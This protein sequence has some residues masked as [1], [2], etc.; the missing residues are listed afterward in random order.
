MQTTVCTGLKRQLKKIG[1][2]DG[3]A[4]SSVEQWSA[5]LERITASYS[6]SDSGRELLE[7]S[8]AL[9]SKEMQELYENFR[10]TSESRLKSEQDRIQRIID[11]APDVVISMN[12]EGNILDWTLALPN[13]EDDPELAN[14]EILLAIYQEWYEEQNPL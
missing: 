7:R 2:E 8:L 6:E 14:D 10:R 9:S 13:F 12:A 11:Q 5:L 4:P 1:L 3:A